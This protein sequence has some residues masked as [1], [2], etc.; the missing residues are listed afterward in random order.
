MI[1]LKVLSYFPVDMVQQKYM[2]KFNVT[3]CHS[4]N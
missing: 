3:F 2:I 4:I 1:D